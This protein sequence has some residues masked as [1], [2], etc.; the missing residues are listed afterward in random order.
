VV[1]L[2]AGIS[3]LDAMLLSAVGALGAALAAVAAFGLTLALQ[4]RVAGT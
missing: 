2:I 4:R 3:L 1:S